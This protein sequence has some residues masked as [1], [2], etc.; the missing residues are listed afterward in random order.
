MRFRLR[1]LLVVAST[2]A[3]TACATAPVSVTDDTYASRRLGLSLILRGLAGPNATDCGM[4]EFNADRTAVDSCLA[5][6]LRAN[7]RAIAVYQDTDPNLRKIVRASGF[8]VLD[9]KRVYFVRWESPMNGDEPPPTDKI[10]FQLCSE[11]RVVSG[12]LNRET[13]ACW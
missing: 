8:L 3:V 4:V 13:L 6:A 2:T 5:A 11:P 9:A 12:Y 10:S 1:L 7:H